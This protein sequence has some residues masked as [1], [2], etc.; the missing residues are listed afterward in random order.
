MKYELD[1]G[2]GAIGYLKEDV[3]AGLTQIYRLFQFTS[4][5]LKDEGTGIDPVVV[6]QAIGRVMES[7]KRA[8][9]ENK[10]F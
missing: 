9:F 6:S 2:K 8:T 3:I 5:T 4:L 10:I 1:A 7:V